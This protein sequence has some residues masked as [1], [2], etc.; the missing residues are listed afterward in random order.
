MSVQIKKLNKFQLTVVWILT[1]IHLN[2]G[3]SLPALL[4][5]FEPFLKLENLC[6][7]SQVYSLFCF[8]LWMLNGDF[9]H[10]STLPCELCAGPW[11]PVK[12]L[13]KQVTGLYTP[14][15]AWWLKVFL[16]STSSEENNLRSQKRRDLQKWFIPSVKLLELTRLSKRILVQTVASRYTADLKDQVTAES[17]CT[18]KGLAFPLTA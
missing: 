13:Q 5:I 12:P 4:L 7:K 3:A 10:S 1:G 6:V 18:V 8:L 14:Q 16:T 11:T 17:K 2:F 15:S 9:F